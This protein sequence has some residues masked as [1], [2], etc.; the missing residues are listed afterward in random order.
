MIPSRKG[1]IIK[2]TR[3]LPG[4]L[5]H[6]IIVLRSYLKVT[7]LSWRVI[8]YDSHY[9]VLLK[10]PYLAWENVNCSI[11]LFFKKKLAQITRSYELYSALASDVTKYDVIV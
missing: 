4:V 5:E 1:I 9:C 7:S 2:P 6:L 8:S 3:L 11:A 10:R